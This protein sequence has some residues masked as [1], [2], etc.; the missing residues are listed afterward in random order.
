MRVIEAFDEA[1]RAV[2]VSP[3]G[4]FVAAT[5]GNH[6]AV[7][8]WLSGTESSWL[9]G[10][11]VGD[12]GS[13]QLAFATDG[14][15]LGLA[16]RNCVVRL[17]P[18]NGNLVNVPSGRCAGGVAVSPDGKVFVATGAG[19]QQ[20]VKLEQWELPSWRSKTGIDYWSPFERLAFSPNGE[21][22]AGINRESFELRFAQ[23][24][25]LNRRELA[26]EESN[27]PARFRRPLYRQEPPRSA[28]LTFPRHSETV[29]FG[30]DGV[31]RVMETRAGNVLRRV[32]SPGEP[33]ADAAFLGSG[34]HLATVDGTPVMRVWS[35]DTWRV[36]RE[37][38]WAAG[39][40][41]CVT[42]TADGLTGVCGTDTGKL[43]VFDVDE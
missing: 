19:Q 18:T 27:L 3:D 10:D 43:V 25:G 20:H 7:W 17:A 12:R 21:H 11:W 6:L 13:S 29:V 40:L 34:R 16:T 9:T 33:F 36:V 41:T 35:A 4:R 31:F 1:V 37:Y 30:W 2:A 8:Y 42:A 39:G 28:F 24:G 15:W 32:E 38:D 22:I 5:G 23:S 26:I 14:S